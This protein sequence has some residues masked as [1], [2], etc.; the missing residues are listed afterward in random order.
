MAW[1]AIINTVS[2]TEITITAITIEFRIAEMEMDTETEMTT[3][4]IARTG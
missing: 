3:D 2:T 1:I 4:L